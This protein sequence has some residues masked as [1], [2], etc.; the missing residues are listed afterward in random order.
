MRVWDI[1]DNCYDKSF[2][3]GMKNRVITS[4]YKYGNLKKE[5]QRVDVSRDELQNAKFRIGAYE[6][7]GNPEYLID[8]ANFLMFEFMEVKGKFLATDGGKYSKII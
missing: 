2:V 1:L 4:H 6:E 7:S 5:K 3:D 8:A